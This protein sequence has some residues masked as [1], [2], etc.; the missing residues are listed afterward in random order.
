MKTRL[1]YSLVF[2]LASGFGLSAQ[3]AGKDLN[4]VKRHLAQVLDH[5]VSEGDP[6]ATIFTEAI[7]R[8][9]PGD[10]IFAD[11][12]RK[13]N[14]MAAEARESKEK[15]KKNL[16]TIKEVTTDVPSYVGTTFT[17]N[18]KISLDTYYNWGYNN[19]KLTHYSLSIKDDRFNRIHAYVSKDEFG[20]GL[21]KILLEK[22]DD[23]AGSF[24]LTILAD[25]QRANRGDGVLAELIGY[26]ATVR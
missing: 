25:R 22:G 24:T 6:K 5:L 16:V 15:K 14:R 12:F 18:G 10:P 3:D 23:V 21:R 7:K 17:V 8:D 9:F 19:A 26:G 4:K 20:K 13:A 1:L 11:V 2:I